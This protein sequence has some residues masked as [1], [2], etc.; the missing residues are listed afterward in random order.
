MKK[1]AF[2]FVLLAFAC[3]KDKDPAPSDLLVGNWT[4]DLRPAYDIT[5][6]IIVT[7][8]NNIYIATA[9][10]IKFGTVTP[11]TP[12]TVTIS[13]FTEFKSLDNFQIEGTAQNGTFSYVFDDCKIIDDNSLVV[14]KMTYKVGS[15][16]TGYS[17]GEVTGGSFKRN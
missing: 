4:Y 7:K 9:H 14:R 8:T 13:R 1:Y 3:G 5:A 17:V 6:S 11:M 10:D 15:S 16:G 12:N 2:I